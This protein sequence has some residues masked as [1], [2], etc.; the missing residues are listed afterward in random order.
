MWLKL[1]AVN[2]QGAWIDLMRVVA[3]SDTQVFMESG[4]SF[5]ISSEDAGYLRGWVKEHRQEM[6]RT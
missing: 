1:Y 4:V 3:F 5:S 6:L 2:G